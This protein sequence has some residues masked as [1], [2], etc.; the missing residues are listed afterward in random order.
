[1]N[2]ISDM[3][4]EDLEAKIKEMFYLII[5]CRDALPAI[6]MTAAKIHKINLSLANRIDE[7]LI[8]FETTEDDPNGI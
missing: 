7:C 4:R 6:T 3:S 1:M 5:E 8:P 2:K